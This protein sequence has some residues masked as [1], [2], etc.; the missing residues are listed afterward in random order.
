MIKKIKIFNTLLTFLFILFSYTTTVTAE[1]IS[2]FS[3]VITLGKNDEITVT[4]SI[5]YDS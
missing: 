1:K 2:S 5:T 3:S 4:E